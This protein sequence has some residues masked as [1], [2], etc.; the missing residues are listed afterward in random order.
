MLSQLFTM[1]PAAPGGTQSKNPDGFFFSQ[2]SLMRRLSP[3]GG[4]VTKNIKKSQKTLAPP[5]L[6]EAMRR[7]A[8]AKVT[9]M[10]FMVRV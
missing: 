4:L 7:G 3:R 6:G 9:L 1:K 5:C 2:S 10:I 8:L